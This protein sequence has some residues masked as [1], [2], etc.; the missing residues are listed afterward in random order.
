MVPGAEESFFGWFETTLPP[1]IAQYYAAATQVYLNPWFFA[2]VTALLLIERARPAIRDQ[3]VLSWGLFDDFCWFNLDLVFNVA[4]LP[5]FVGLVNL[6]Y[7]KLTGGFSFGFVA[8][9]P[10]WLRVAFS[11]LVYDFLQWVHHFVRHKVAWLWSFHV[12]HHSQTEMN[13]FTDLRVHF[14]GTW[15][16]TC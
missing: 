15:R 11:L 6:G 12:I 2:G 10:I 3:K 1:T 16:P 5:A 8:G 14:G 9:W 13:L 4:A 7:D